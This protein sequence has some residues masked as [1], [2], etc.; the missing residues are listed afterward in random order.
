MPRSCVGWMLWH[1]AVTLLGELIGRQERSRRGRC[2]WE[3]SGV[4][5]SPNVSEGVLRCWGCFR[6]C[7]QSLALC[8]YREIKGKH[9]PGLRYRFVPK[10][11]DL[12]EI[13]ES[14]LNF[15]SRDG[16]LSLETRRAALVWG[17]TCFG[18]SFAGAEGWCST[19]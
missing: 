2:R 8:K 19:G 14:V 3:L 11:E 5:V 17:W 18:M 7:R 1:G 6:G 13:E 10:T 12:I 4:V 15:F 16:N 9:F